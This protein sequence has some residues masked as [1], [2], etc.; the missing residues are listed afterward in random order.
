M[1][2][3]S[4][5]PAELA[6]LFELAPVSLWLEDYSAVRDQFQQW[7]DEGVTDFR[8]FLRESPDRVAL[9]S[10]LIRVVAVNRRTLELFEADS[11]EH[12]VANMADIFRGDMFDQHVEELAQL[13]EGNGRFHSQTVNYALSGKRLEILLHGTV[14]SGSEASWRRVLIAIEDITER[15]EAQRALADAER[16]ARGLFDHSPVSLWV[17]DFSGIKKLLDEVAASGVT[18]FR[19]FTD[20]H[21]EFVQRCIEQLRVIDVNRQTLTM[22]GAP[23][24]ETLVENA[25]RIFRDDMEQHFREQLAKLF[26][27]ELVHH[28]ESVNYTLTGDRLNVYLQLSVL[29]GS[30]SDWKLVLVSLMDITARKKAEAYLEYLGTHDPMSKLRNRAFFTEELKRVNRRGPWPVTIVAI[31]LN[32]LKETNDTQGHATGDALIRRAGEVLAK[33]VEGDICAAR[34]G[35]DE[36]AL[37]LPATDDVGGQKIMSRIEE[38]VALNNRFYDG[39]PLSF[40]M[41]MATG[42]KGASLEDV[43]TRAD[44]RMYENKREYYM[45]AGIDQRRS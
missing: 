31:D 43:M 11:L 22:F 25:H 9:C 5:D 38:L 3:A 16:Y 4:N 41:G 6:E 45:R 15:I 20:V 21:P 35:G 27:G 24:R 32:H 29:P 13:W 18:D 26:E 7:R 33:T 2:A 19:T 1:P 17:E 8:A 42:D 14:L 34:I 28:R 37:L 23:D 40:A 12:L 39:P 10:S 30:E 44:A 36:F